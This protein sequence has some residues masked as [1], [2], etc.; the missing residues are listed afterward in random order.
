MEI[1]SLI[2]VISVAAMLFGFYLGQVWLSIIFF[3]VLC[4]ALLST[5]KEKRV[6][7]S[8]GPAI[9]PIIVKR[10]YVGPESIYPKEMKIKIT[11]KEFGTGRPMSMMAASGFGKF[12]G[13]VVKKIFD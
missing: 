13:K 8:D 1:E 3:V 9:R 5:Q 6:S 10:H 7:V 4:A 12:I 11:P 2:A